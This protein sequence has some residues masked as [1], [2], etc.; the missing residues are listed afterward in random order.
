LRNPKFKE[1]E[2]SDITVKAVEA[3]GK[4]AIVETGNGLKYLAGPATEPKDLAAEVKK[5][6]SFC[7]Q[8]YD[9][10]MQAL[11]DKFDYMPP[12]DC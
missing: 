11:L 9:A 4:V 1:F 10:C 3:G 12:A 8:T 6:F 7:S 2:M 5:K